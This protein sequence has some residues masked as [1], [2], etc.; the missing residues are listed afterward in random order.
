MNLPAYAF[1]RLVT[2]NG[3]TFG[4]HCPSNGTLSYFGYNVT[5]G[6]TDALH[7]VILNLDTRPVI[8]DRSVT[9]SCSSQSLLPGQDTQ[10]PSVVL[11][12]VT[13]ISSCNSLNPATTQDAEKA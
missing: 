8:L 7:S 4:F 13:Q 5:H 9:Q 2:V 3:S 10:F 1:Q 6:C 12:H 11:G